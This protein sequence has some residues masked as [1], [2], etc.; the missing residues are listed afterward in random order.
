MLFCAGSVYTTAP[1]HNISLEV[2][3][4]TVWLF[5]KGKEEFVWQ[6]KT[7]AN[8]KAQIFKSVHELD[9]ACLDFCRTA[10]MSSS[11]L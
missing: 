1:S 3:L 8:S 4:S 5:F 6:P 10:T 9:L 11:L 7:H 2:E